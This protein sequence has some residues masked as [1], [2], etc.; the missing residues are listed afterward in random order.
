[1]QIEDVAWIRF[2]SWRSAQEERHF[3]IRN[4][5]LGEIVVDAECVAHFL[6]VNGDALFHDLFCNRATGERRKVLQWCWIFGACDH[7]DGVPHGALLLQHGNNGAHR[8]ELLA[9]CNVDAD[10]A[11]PLLIDDRVNRHGGLA[12][13]AVTDDQLALS[14]TDWDECINR[15]DT[16]LHWRGD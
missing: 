11:L 2:A 1:M 7:N 4:G 15:L 6:P 14:A 16:S 10:E 9:D 13:L 3:A 12:G 8:G 5:V